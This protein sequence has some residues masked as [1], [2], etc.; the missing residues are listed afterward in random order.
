[1]C[2]SLKVG[3]QFFI[4][5]LFCRR[6][7]GVLISLHLGGEGGEGFLSS[8][9]SLSGGGGIFYRRGRGLHAYLQDWLREGVTGTGDWKEIMHFMSNLFSPFCRGG[10]FFVETLLN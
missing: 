3:K 2:P 8:Y 9:L 4:N 1:M 5:L 7:R 6:G 10:C